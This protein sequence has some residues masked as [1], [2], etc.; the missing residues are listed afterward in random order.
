[1]LATNTSNLA[2][3]SREG[4]TGRGCLLGNLSGGLA[5]SVMGCL[6]APNARRF[7]EHRCGLGP[8][9]GKSLV[10]ICSG[11]YCP[12][13]LSPALVGAIAGGPAEAYA[14]VPLELEPSGSPSRR[15]P[16]ARERRMG[17]STSRLQAASEW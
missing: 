2:G 3:D 8:C 13:I 6:S 7:F 1:M 14:A 16:P 4:V 12:G 9:P 15:R 5:P 11:R 17:P 10:R